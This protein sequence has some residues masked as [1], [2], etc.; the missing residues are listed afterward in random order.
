MN[1]YAARN[2]LNNLFIKLYYRFLHNLK[3]IDNDKNFKNSFTSKLGT[4]WIFSLYRYKSLLA[5]TGLKFYETNLKIFL[6]EEKISSLVIFKDFPPNEILLN[7]DYIDIT[8]QIAKKLKIKFYT[9]N[10]IKQK[11][12][13]NLNVFKNLAKIFLKY[14]INFYKNQLSKIKSYLISKSD[15]KGIFEPLYELKYI[16]FS[17]KNKFIIYQDAD[18]KL[19]KFFYNIKFFNRDKFINKKL[20]NKL[21]TKYSY[22]YIVK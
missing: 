7:E 18:E 3:K 4:N 13:L 11:N 20:I 8:R 14:L 22:D 1:S 6:K 5:Y 2:R 15:N 17:Q 16:N 9:N 21:I 10:F 19:K 12:N